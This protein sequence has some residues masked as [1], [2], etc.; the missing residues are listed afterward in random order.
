MTQTTLI[1]VN[2][3]LGVV[4][5]YALAGL[6]SFGIHSDQSARKAHSRRV[7]RPEPKRVAA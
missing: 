1:S 2:A 3:I 6:L 5:V 7:R 4:V